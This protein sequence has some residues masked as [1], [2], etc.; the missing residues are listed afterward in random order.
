MSLLNIG[1]IFLDKNKME[2]LT[3]N[4]SVI[5]NNKPKFNK[6]NKKKI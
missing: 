3:L 4:L 2:K 1:K 6:L 5:C